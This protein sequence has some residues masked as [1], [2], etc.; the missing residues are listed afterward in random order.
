[1][2]D[3]RRR[4]KAALGI[5]LIVV[6]IGAAL[7][8]A[9]LLTRYMD[10]RVAEARVP[11]EKVAVA[12]VDI[13]VASPIAA[14]WIALV[15][16]PAAARP[17]GAVTNPATLVGRVALVPIAKGE[18]VLPGKLVEAGAR[19]G[20]ATLLAPGARAVAVRVDDVVGVA[21]FL[22]PGDRVDVIATMKPRDEAPFVSKI[23]LQD[24][25]VLAVGKDLEQRAKDA[26]KAKPATVAT[27]MVTP[28]ESE[29]LA[30]AATKGQLL[31]ALRGIGDEAPIAT[32]GAVPARLLG[33]A[34]P[35]PPPPPAA[36]VVARVAA[37]R[38]AP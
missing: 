16:W 33:A 4:R 24:V 38:R 5:A 6:A 25:K 2:K 35:P 30:L 18:P 15:D 37:V 22:H 9:S 26:E 10:R 21:G 1:M 11:V 28:E 17:V 29:R 12:R 23:I 27:V 13:P 31:L 32:T 8:A 36:P 34:L 20:L 7:A 14:D 3:R 19:A